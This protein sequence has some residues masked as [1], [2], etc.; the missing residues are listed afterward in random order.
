V[1]RLVV[2]T[3]QRSTT[4]RDAVHGVPSRWV[5]EMKLRQVRVEGDP[6]DRLTLPRA[7][8]A[9]RAALAAAAIEKSAGRGR[10]LLVRVAGEPLRQVIDQLSE[11]QSLICAQA[12]CLDRP[13]AF[14][15]GVGKAVGVHK[16]LKT[17]NPDPHVFVQRRAVHSVQAVAAFVKRAHHRYVL[18]FGMR[19]YQCLPSGSE[20]LSWV[21]VAHPSLPF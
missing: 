19:R 6:R 8:A 2:T 12:A 11:L 7:A 18:A 1:Q 17:V 16:A 5:G 10:A 4:G 20:S 15:A 21:T 13:R 9:E 14:A 3:R